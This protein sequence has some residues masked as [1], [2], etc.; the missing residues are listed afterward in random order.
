[1]QNTL[2]I[3]SI[4][5]QELQQKG[6]N[7]SRFSQ[8]SGM[9]RGTLSLILN[10]NP[11]KLPSIP[12]MDKIA[13]ALGYEQGWLYELYLEECFDREVP[14]WRRLKNFLYRCIQLDKEEL[15]DKALHR[16]MEDCS[17]TAA[18]FDAAEEWYEEGYRQVLLPFYRYVTVNEKY[19][20]AERLAISHYRIF[21]LSQSENFE[22]NLRSAITFEPYRHELPVGFRLDGLLKLTHVYYNQHMWEKVEFFADELHEL[23]NHVYE[24]R[25]HMSNNIEAEKG[26][27]TERHL[28]VYYGQGYVMKGNALFLQERYDE[29]LKY[30]QKYEDLSWFEGLYEDGK[31]EVNKLSSFAR[32][33]FL[34][35]NLLSGNKDSLSEYLELLRNDVNE[36]LPGLLFVIDAAN[37]YDFVIDNI[38]EEF[39]DEV[40]KMEKDLQTKNGY[41]Q[42]DISME[43][44]IS[45]YKKLAIYF[46]K[47]HSYNKAIDNVIK[48]ISLSVKAN[49]KEDLIS[50]VSLF[51]LYR[52]YATDFQLEQYHQFMRE[53]LRI[54][55][56][57][58]SKIINSSNC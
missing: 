5:E 14:H 11:S 43:R 10:G 36:M 34:A 9:N 50:C 53:V 55:E 12:Q 38:I 42:S 23:S 57:Y 8:V 25:L 1:M 3:R 15:I 49:S 40:V 27:K 39:L 26:L 13:E 47:E 52:R 30:I 4:V 58:I 41:Y 51:E 21:R 45:L 54:E 35:I 56:A 20:H 17:Q 31:R 32:A 2:N 29:A 18:V 19:R 28:V 16:L 7:L 33:N 24:N 6:Y 46:F 37:K 44:Y 22:N 48:C